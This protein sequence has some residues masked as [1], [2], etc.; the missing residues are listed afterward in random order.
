MR[1]MK[2]ILKIID[3]SYRKSLF[4]V[5]YAHPS[6]FDEF[7][8]YKEELG[9]DPLED[10]ELKKE[11]Q[12]LIFLSILRT[13]GKLGDVSREESEIFFENFEK[14]TKKHKN[15]TSATLNFG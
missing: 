14:N 3:Y 10:L 2:K 8:S 4:Q 6:R 11:F 7:V 5:R 15:H 12:K 9:L 13:Y 1:G